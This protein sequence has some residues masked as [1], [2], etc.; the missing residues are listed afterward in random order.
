MRPLTA[1]LYNLWQLTRA[2]LLYVP[3]LFGAAFVLAGIGLFL[4]DLNFKE[5]FSDKRFIYN[6]DI[7]EA[8][9]VIQE[10]SS[11]VKPF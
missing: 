3:A 5:A 7:E 11:S 6:G 1:R 8:S 4:L 10:T 2:S 9:D